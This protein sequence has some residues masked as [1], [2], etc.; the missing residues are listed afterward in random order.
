MVSVLLIS[1]GVAL[2]GGVMIAP[3]AVEKIVGNTEVAVR[4]AVHE[5][6][7]PGTLPEI[8]LGP[9]GGMREMDQC[10]GT[11][12]EMISYRM[13]EVLPLYA[14][15]HRCGGD[16]ILGWELGE[17]VR[18]A[19]SD[20]I[21]EVVE[22]RHTPKWSQVELLKGMTGEFM[23]QTCYYG[24]NKMRFLALAPAADQTAP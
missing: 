3:D 1:A 2:L 19:G 5:I 16:I 8:T 4:K 14:A 10:D 12:T 9:E 6:V 23:V 7:A 11:F 22:E 21:Y 17:R 18:V 13:D 20:V 24:E 15:H